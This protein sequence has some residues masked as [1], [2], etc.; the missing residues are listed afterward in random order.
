M[1]TITCCQQEVLF[2]KEDIRYFMNY[3][4]AVARIIA[5]KL[6]LT[7]LSSRKM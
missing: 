5:P 1:K 2:A 7:K 3:E 6:D 4:M